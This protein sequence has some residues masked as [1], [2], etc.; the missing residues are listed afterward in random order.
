M[1]PGKVRGA[2]LAAP[3]ILVIAVFIGLPVVSSVLYTFGHTGGLN[4]V[5]AE[6]AQHQFV[7]D[8]WWG[9]LGAYRDVFGAGSFWRSLWSTVLVTV[10]T[11]ALVLLLAGAVALYLRLSGGRLARAVS[12]LAVVPL[13]IP[14]VIASYAILVF[15]APDGFLRSVTQLLG[16]PDAPVLSY[17]MVGVT[18]G[19]VWVNLPFG[20]LLL[21]SAFGSVPD[22]LIDAARDAGAS[23]PR[24]VRSVLA[25]MSALPAT[26]VAT[27]TAISVLG[28]FTVPYLIGPS[29]P[30]MLGPEMANTFG[31]FNQ[32][33]QAEVMAV[34]VFLLATVAAIYYLRANFRAS[35]RSGADR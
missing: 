11:T 15:Y 24:V 26:I 20:V 9:T 16:W 29:A 17:T 12:L 27:F 23:L 31:P 34:V 21:S 4:S 14:V 8:H 13:F 7:A 5:V 33:Q 22:T 18:I 3:P 25:P 28:S 2:L 10:A 19:Q 32:P 30:N 1:A 35:K 6:L